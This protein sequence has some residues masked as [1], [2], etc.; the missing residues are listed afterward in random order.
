MADEW[1]PSIEFVNMPDGSLRAQETMEAMVRD[2][3]NAH[4]AARDERVKTVLRELGWF[5]PEDI[6]AH[7]RTERAAA[8]DKALDGFAV[9]LHNVTVNGDAIPKEA[10]AREVA[11]YNIDL[12]VCSSCD[13]AGGQH[14]RACDVDPQWADRT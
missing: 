4:S 7:D 1:V 12:R 2:I 9:A 10:F 6:E 8:S 14:A 13:M 5:A 11:A 3:L